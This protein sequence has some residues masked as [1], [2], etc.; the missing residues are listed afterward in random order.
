[1]KSVGAIHFRAEL[2]RTGPACSVIARIIGGNSWLLHRLFVQSERILRTDGMNIIA[3]DV[4]EVTQVRLCSAPH[5]A[6]R[7]PP[8]IVEDHS[9]GNK[10]VYL[11]ALN[12]DFLQ[13]PMAPTVSP[14]TSL[15][16]SNFRFRCYRTP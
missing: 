4:A 11:S 13:G 5:N 1:M 9:L 2:H 6:E 12:G 8:F 15:P 3:N 16:Q 10:R 14:A 7:T